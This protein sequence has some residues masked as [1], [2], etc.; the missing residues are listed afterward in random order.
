MP[1][2]G[3][4][5]LGINLDRTNADDLIDHPYIQGFLRRN[6]FTFPS[7]LVVTVPA[8]IQT[9]TRVPLQ[10]GL[11]FPA[12]LTPLSSLTSFPSHCSPHLR[13]RVPLPK[14]CGAIHGEESRPTMAF[15]SLIKVAVSCR[16]TKVKQSSRP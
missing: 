14:G 10:R 1:S 7:V 6:S 3:R 5:K 4:N 12:P 9:A 15:Y 16:A 11:S 13:P 2:L 8:G